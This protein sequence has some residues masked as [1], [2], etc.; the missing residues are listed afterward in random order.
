VKTDGGIMQATMREL[1][2]SC[3]PTDIPEHFELDVADLGIGDSIHVRDISIP[4]TDIRSE[5]QRTVV[6]ISA[7]TVIKEV[8]EVAE[9]EEIE[10][11]AAAEEAPA[12]GEAAKEGEAPSAE[13]EKAKPEEKK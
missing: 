5:T 11:E 13:A 9:G 2:I 12:E 6:V 7:P 1:E 8:V 10:G 4:N 3:L